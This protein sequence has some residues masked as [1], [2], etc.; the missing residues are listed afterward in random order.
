M[1]NRDM[2]E[3]LINDNPNNADCTCELANFEIIKALRGKSRGAVWNS[4]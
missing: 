3:L 1:N 4:G 2:V